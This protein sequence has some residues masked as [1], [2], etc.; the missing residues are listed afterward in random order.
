MLRLALTIAVF[1]LTMVSLLSLDA[2]FAGTR[3]DD[4][5]D[6]S[7]GQADARIR[8]C[9]RI[10]NS[11]RLFGKPISKKDLAV[12]Y[13]NRGNAYYDKGE[14]DCA[15]ADFDTAIK[16]NP[17]YADAYSNRGNAYYDKREY[18]RAISDYDQ[19]IKLNPKNAK[20][21]YNRGNAYDDRGEI[22]RAIADYDQAIKLNPKYADAYF[23][24]GV[25]YRKKG[26]KERGIAN[27]RKALALN[28]SHES[29]RKSL[30]TLGKTP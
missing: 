15:I 19:A 14:L 11:E 30:K 8:G 26:E 24:R 1:S 18:D 7:K 27:Y 16:L 9:S 6:R 13:N 4:V 29:A 21:Y 12:A 22:N 5:A 17:I 10:I 28:P 2:R 23:N 20:A 3:A 25:A